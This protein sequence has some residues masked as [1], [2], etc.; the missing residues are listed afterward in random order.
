MLPFKHLSKP[1]KK[2]CGGGGGGGVWVGEVANQITTLCPQI[3]NRSTFE[4]VFCHG[5]MEINTF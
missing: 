2:V 5:K 3:K 1:N 4:H